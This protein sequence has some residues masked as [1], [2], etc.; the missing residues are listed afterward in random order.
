MH[1]STRVASDDLET[2]LTERKS[3]VADADGVPMLITGNE[4]I[5]FEHHRTATV[6]AQ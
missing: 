6:F 3:A 1:T 5:V 2:R 4:V